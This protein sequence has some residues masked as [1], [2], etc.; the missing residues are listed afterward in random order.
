[1]KF[2]IIKII[3]LNNKFIIVK[4][5][6]KDIF[7]SITLYHAINLNLW[8]KFFQEHVTYCGTINCVKLFLR[9]IRSYCENIIG[10]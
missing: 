6:K 3:K 2:I 9:F 5:I 8:N 7:I 4:V 10:K 1:M